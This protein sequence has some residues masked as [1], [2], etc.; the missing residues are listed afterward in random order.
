MRKFI[1]ISTVVL[2]ATL[3][4]AAPSFEI[5]DRGDAVEII[6]HEIKATRMVVIPTRQRLEVAIAPGANVARLVPKDATVR[7]IEL[8]TSG[9]VRVLSVKL[10]FERGQV[11]TLAKY[12]QSIQVG[13]DLHVLIPRNL[14]VEGKPFAMPEPT[15]PA[16][17]PK[18]F[19]PQDPFA[20]KP[21]TGGDAH[22]GAHGAGAGGAHGNAAGTGTNGTQPGANTAGH[23]TTS[24]G[25]D[26]HGT[27]AGA[28][29]G[30]NTAGH[31][32]TSAAPG[33]DRGTTAGTHGSDGATPAGKG[34]D[35][36][37]TA[38]G[39]GPADASAHGATDARAGKKPL[40]LADEPKT[41][42][43]FQ[44]M[45]AGALVLLGGLVWLK[46]KKKGAT[47]Q[48]EATID[49][50]AQRSIGGKAKIVWLTAGGREMV[51]A[52]TPQKVQMLGQWGKGGGPGPSS[53][54]VNREGP[55]TRGELPEAR[56]HGPKP[57]AAVN[58]ILKLRER[59]S[60]R[61]IPTTGLNL[62]LEN[63][64]DVATGD[65][66]ADE[67]WAREMLAAQVRR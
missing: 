41:G 18:V 32:T 49:V 24:G 55:S 27:T 14:P 16:A 50:V 8:D 13:D 26:G 58:G 5:I 2:S 10:G 43:S 42:S 33:I 17:P 28:T 22:V 44:M 15:L 54:S 62:N 67:M 37:G 56:T 47:K 59:A 65:Y 11:K 20:G 25:I 64:E 66:E 12:A 19:G 52:V 30:A 45:V 61:E 29:T 23:G 3:A 1:I 4:S 39:H 51:V 40:K 36:H 35:G 60:M 6:A 31:G 34:S 53:S 46:K 57:S 9:G 48:A 7:Q 21:S 63:H 38:G